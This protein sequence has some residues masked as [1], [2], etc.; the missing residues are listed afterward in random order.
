MTMPALALAHM[1]ASQVQHT[2]FGLLSGGGSGHGVSG[3]HGP[4]ASR[5]ADRRRVRSGREPSRPTLRRPRAPAATMLT[6]RCRR[7]CR[8]SAR[9]RSSTA[10][11]RPPRWSC[12]RCGGT[13]DQEWGGARTRLCEGRAA[14]GR[15]QERSSSVLVCRQAGRAFPVCGPRHGARCGAAQVL[16][17]SAQQAGQRA[18]CGRPT[19]CGVLR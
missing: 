8:W 4:A 7:R 15:R 10:W 12:A 17:R 3:G 6:G 1:R 13:Q 18:G 9:P 16:T 11:A 14:S 2:R 19:G 5:E